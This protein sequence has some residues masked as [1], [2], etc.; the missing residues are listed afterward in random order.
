MPGKEKGW[1]R[2]TSHIEQ[3][4]ND[5]NIVEILTVNK[6]NKH[7]LKNYYEQHLKVINKALCYMFGKLKMYKK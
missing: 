5:C 7:L 1:L 2:D 6:V 4:R 3:R